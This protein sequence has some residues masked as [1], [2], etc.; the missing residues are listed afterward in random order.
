M[1]LCLW[2]RWRQIEGELTG[3]GE[4]LHGARK[5]PCPGLPT[6]SWQTAAPQR[7][8]PSLTPGLF[9]S[10]LTTGS[11]SV[12]PPAGSASSMCGFLSRRTHLPSVPA[13]GGCPE[14]ASHWCRGQEEASRQGPTDYLRQAWWSPVSRGQ[15]ILSRAGPVPP[16]R[17]LVLMVQWL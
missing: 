11:G 12:L 10:L 17:I 2:D 1:C 14:A 15:A 6:S 9:T 13:E 5:L 8:L 7:Q 4:M 3:P 16:K